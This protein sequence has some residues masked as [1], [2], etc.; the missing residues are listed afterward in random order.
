MKFKN[1]FKV[2]FLAKYIA[3]FKESGFKAV[4][5]STGKIN[6]RFSSFIF[7]LENKSIQF[8]YE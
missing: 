2:K 3:I 4:F 1:P 6:F 7:K 5:C 8:L